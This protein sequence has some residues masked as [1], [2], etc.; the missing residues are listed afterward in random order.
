LDKFIKKAKGHRSR[1]KNKFWEL[2]PESFSD[3]DILELLLFF[4]IPRKDTRYIART[5]LKKFNNRLD[6]VL[7]APDSELLK[8]EGIGKNAII[9][10]KVVKEV[11]KRYLKHKA[12]KAYFLKSPQAVFEYLQYELK[13]LDREVFMVIYLDANSGVIKTEKL[14]EGTLT[15]AVVYPREVFAKALQNKA[16]SLI[17]VHNHPSGNL[18]PS[19]EDINLTKKLILAGL[20]LQINILDHII[21]SKNGYFSMAEE[22]IIEKLNNEAYKLFRQ[23]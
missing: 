12:E 2:G 13:G 20:L 3:E 10:L 11:A 23:R 9:P 18:K 5:L 6:E 7:D 22:G 17:L 1:V 21:V 16:V 19:S 15:E 8:I 14:F 4:G